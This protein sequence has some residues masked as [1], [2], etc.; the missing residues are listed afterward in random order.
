[1]EN[2]FIRSNEQVACIDISEI[3]EQNLYDKFT[4]NNGQTIYVTDCG[5]VQGMITVGN[6]LRNCLDKGELI[7]PQ[8]TRVSSKNEEEALKILHK[9][10]W[11]ESLP[12]IN[13]RN[14]IVK[15]YYRRYYFLGKERTSEIYKIIKQIIYEIRYFQKA[16]QIVKMILYSD[17][18]DSRQVQDLQKKADGTIV[19]LNRISIEQIKNY[20]EKGYQYVCDFAPESYRVRQAF[21]EKYGIKGIKWEL[22]W[23]EIGGCFADRVNYFKKNGVAVFEGDENCIMKWIGDAGVQSLNCEKFE[24]NVQMGCLEYMGELDNQIECIFTMVCFLDN[25]YI[26]RRKGDGYHYIPILSG[27]YR[28]NQAGIMASEIDIVTNILPVIQKHNNKFLLLRDPDKESEGGISSQLKKR[29]LNAKQIQEHEKVFWRDWEEDAACRIREIKTNLMEMKDGFL[30]R[31]DMQGKYVN[32]ID[33]ERYTVGN[34]KTGPSVF[35]LFGPCTL[36]GT[37]V[38]DK[39]TIPS[40][41]RPMIPK[42]YYIKNHAP[43]YPNINYAIRAE[44]Y[45]NGDIIMFMIS[46]IDLFEQVGIKTYSILPAYRNIPDLWDNVKDQLKHCNSIAMK[47]IAEEIYHILM[48][49][50]FL[51][52]RENDNI[53]ANEKVYFGTGKRNIPKELKKWLTVT[54]QRY[55]I[56]NAGKAGAVVMNCNPFTRGHRYLIETASERVDVL[57]IFVLEEDKSYFDFQSRFEMVKDG[58]NDLSNVVVIPGGKYVIS[59]QTMPGYFNKEDMP[60]VEA[61]AAM[62]LSFF[63]RAIAKEFEIQVR[64]AGEEPKDKFTKKYNEAM[65]RILPGYGIEFCEIPR[66]LLGKSVISASLVR[67]YMKEHEYELIKD[68]VPPSTYDYLRQKFFVS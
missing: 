67:K 8:F 26:V 31:V 66:K 55:K 29:F 30:Q 42:Q 28:D 22:E 59:T 34:E 49:E 18:I 45:R 51:E 61:D 64:F 11:M 24:W 68:L 23:N 39:Y 48:Q 12:V 58:T 13:D 14:E 17:C 57:Y 43:K 46:N 25:P 32:C 40:W 10:T 2:I 6:F 16:G 19:V 9:N 7:T 15:E 52:N 1:M 50:H 27:V 37:F 41:L 56:Q 36:I 47:Y 21:Y 63:A 54:S 33:G 35:H 62:D 60:F 65:E 3:S 38:E 53:K 20:A 4:D 44:R 5:K